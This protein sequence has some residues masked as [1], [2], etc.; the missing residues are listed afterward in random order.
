[1]FELDKDI[2]VAVGTCFTSRDRT[3]NAKTTNAG[4][5]QFGAMR[6]DAFEESLAVH[7][8]ALASI[9]ARPAPRSQVATAT[10]LP[11]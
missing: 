3:V 2:H 7:D 5:R 8:N 9:I 11:A 4:T 1:M 6:G 10:A